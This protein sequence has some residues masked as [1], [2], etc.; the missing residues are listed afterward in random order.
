MSVKSTFSSLWAKIKAFFTKSS[1]T[2]TVIKEALA[3]VEPLVVTISTLA[4]SDSTEVTAVLATITS[5]ITK[6]TSLS[7][8]ASNVTSITTLLEDIKTNIG[9]LLSLAAIKNSSKVSSI[10]TYTTLVINELEAVISQLS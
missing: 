5:D 3:Y 4:G 8:S 1:S 9:T 7:T 6:A 2:L 10:T